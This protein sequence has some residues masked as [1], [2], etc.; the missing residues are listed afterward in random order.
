MPYSDEWL[1]EL[2]QPHAGVLVLQENVAVRADVLPRV[3]A[4]VLD[5]L[6]GD[7]ILTRLGYAKSAAVR[8][9]LPTSTQIRSGDI[10]EI[11]ATDY[12]QAKTS[13]VVPL[14]RLRYKDDRNT[15]MRGD[16][17]IALDTRGPAVHVLKAEVKSRAAL[18]TATVK[19]AC[20]A[21]EGNRG[22]PKASSLAFISMRL[23]ERGRDDL[24]ATIEALQE[25]DLRIEQVHHLVFIV[26]GNAPLPHLEACLREPV[27]AAERRFIGL[28]IDN[29]P[30][31]IEAIFGMLDA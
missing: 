9:R 8:N 19:A 14:K 15:S 11:I 23:R 30:A 17:L 22:R 27:S 25:G 13:F 24:A 18:A 20:Q 5:H 3:C 2:N 4:S 1:S 7:D 31:F 29:H 21:L 6:I 12:V 28:Q 10:G 26:C 16:D